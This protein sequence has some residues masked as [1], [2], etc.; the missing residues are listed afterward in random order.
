MDKK[1]EWLTEVRNNR[2]KIYSNCTKETIASCLNVILGG[3]K[4]LCVYVF[5]W[6]NANSFITCKS[7]WRINHIGF[8]ILIFRFTNLLYP[9]FHFE[10]KKIPTQSI[11]IWQFEKD[12]QK[13]LKKREICSLRFAF[14][15]LFLHSLSI[16][17][18]YL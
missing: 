2:S 9:L 7:H 17:M 11:G 18:V 16:Y 10:S 4:Y 3:F 1:N 6:M 8:G 5:A 12:Q 13:Y 15:I 14:S